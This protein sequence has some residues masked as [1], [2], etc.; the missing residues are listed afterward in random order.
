VNYG[1]RQPLKKNVLRFIGFR[2]ERVAGGELS[3]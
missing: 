3:F 2:Q 1:D